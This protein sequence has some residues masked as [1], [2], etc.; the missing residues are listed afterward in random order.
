[1][2]TLASL[3][4]YTLLFAAHAAAQGVAFQSTSLPR[5]MR[6]EGVTEAAGEL[7]LTAL[8]SGTITANSS[9]DFVFSAAITNNSTAST[10]NISLSNNFACNPFSVCPSGTT[11]AT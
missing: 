5:Q 8:N 3:A 2:R 6:Q 4:L 11:T 7:V 9:I 1:M 10:N